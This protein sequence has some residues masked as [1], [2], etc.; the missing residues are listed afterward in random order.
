MLDVDPS[1]RSNVLLSLDVASVDLRRLPDEVARPGFPLSW[2][3]SE[4]NG[5]IFI[6]ALGHFPH[7]WLDESYLEHLL[8]GL[9]YAAGRLPPQENSQETAQGADS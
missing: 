2:T 9:R 3:R 1:P 4:G 6:T 7:V 8:Q 5:R